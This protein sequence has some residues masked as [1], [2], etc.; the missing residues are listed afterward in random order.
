MK[1]ARQ[2][3]AGLLKNTVCAA[4]FRQVINLS[5]L[6]AIPPSRPIRRPIFLTSCPASLYEEWHVASVPK[7]EILHLSLLMPEWLASLNGF[8]GFSP[9][10]IVVINS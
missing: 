6:S 4:S 10:P 9:R 3:E 8:F 2:G 7:S 5:W 1:K